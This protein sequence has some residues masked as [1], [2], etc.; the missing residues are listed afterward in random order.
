M[1]MFGCVINNP[2]SPSIAATGNSSH[3][4]LIYLI[5]PYREE[6]GKIWMVKDRDVVASSGLLFNASV[7]TG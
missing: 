6:P 1:L 2:A 5:G 7:G 4:P 3:P